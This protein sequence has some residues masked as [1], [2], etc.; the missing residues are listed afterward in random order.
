VFVLYVPRGTTEV[1]GTLPEKDR[2]LPW[3]KKVTDG[4]DVEL[5]DP[6]TALR[7]RQATGE[8][9]YDDHWSPDG[10]EVIAQ[11]L[12]DIFCTRLPEIGCARAHSTS[13]D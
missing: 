3:L 2:W 1:N 9:V 12:A 7:N 8:P 6:T 5:L 10:H 13:E 4:L 11:F